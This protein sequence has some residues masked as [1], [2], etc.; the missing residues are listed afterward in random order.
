MRKKVNTHAW[1]A[2]K[3]EGEKQGLNAEFAEEAHRER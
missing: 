2:A 3:F 1:G